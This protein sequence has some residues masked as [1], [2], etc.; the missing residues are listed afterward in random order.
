MLIGGKKVPSIIVGRLL[1]GLSQGQEN[2]EKAFNEQ[3][4]PLEQMQGG[5][6]LQF[7][8]DGIMRAVHEKDVLGLSEKLKAFFEVC[9]K[10]PHEEY[11]DEKIE[12]GG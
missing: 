7:I 5:N 2:N 4:K 9:D 10:M 6:D 3:A 11:Q 12:F 8:A 1:D